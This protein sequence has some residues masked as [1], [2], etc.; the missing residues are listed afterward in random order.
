MK[1]Y[2]QF[3]IEANAARELDEGIMTAGAKVIGK[4]LPK[5]IKAL[6]PAK[7]VAKKS[8]FAVTR[9]MGIGPKFKAQ[10]TPGLRGLTG[11]TRT[12][13][14]G[15]SSD[16]AK[17]AQVK[18]LSSRTG[19]E[20]GS[21]G[22]Q[23]TINDWEKYAKQTGDKT[24]KRPYYERGRAFVTTDK[25]DAETYAR[26]TADLKN[27]G[28]FRRIGLRKKVEPVIMKVSVP[29]KDMRVAKMAGKEY[30]VAT[31]NIQP[32]SVEKVGGKLSDEARKQAGYDK[33]R[34]DRLSKIDPNDPFS[35]YSRQQIKS[36]WGGSSDKK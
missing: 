5:V 31:K 2:K 8:V 7:N 36:S 9:R 3:I 10:T 25:F 35:E 30:T 17:R 4:V 13:Y 21:R 6:K 26:K 32:K 24:F 11:K 1:T 16:I 15:T 27:K 29:K 34:K 28:F 12:L 33:L 18:G 22:M 20:I 23:K 14:H 19:T